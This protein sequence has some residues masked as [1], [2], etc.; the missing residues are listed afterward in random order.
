MAKNI[1]QIPD[2]FISQA[3]PEKSALPEYRSVFMRDRDR[4]MYATAFRRLAGKTQIYT[5]GADD[6][7]KNRLTHSL[8]V[9]QIAR[10][11]ATAL[12]LSEP[13]AEAI[14]LAHDF[15]HTPFGHA[16]EEMLH[17]IM[18]PNSKEV[19]DSPFYRKS[20]K[21]IEEQIERESLSEIV[22]VLDIESIFGFKHNIQSVRVATILEDSYR[23]ENDINIGLNLSNYTLWG[24][25]NHSS[26]K[27]RF[28][29]TQPNYQS[30]FQNMISINGL[31]K[32][33]WSFE[34]YIVKI[35]D[36]IAQW[37]HDLED[38]IRGNAIPIDKICNT[39]TEAIGN[40]LSEEDKDLLV[41][42]SNT[43][44]MTRK[45]LAQLSHIVVN[46]LVNDLVMKSK[47]NLNRLQKEISSYKSKTKEKEKSH[48]LYSR[49]DELYK[50]GKITSSRESII[51]FS[52]KIRPEIFK[53]SIIQSVHHSRNVER[54][55]E[56]GKYIIKKLFQAYSSHPQQMPDG[57]I[58]HFMVEIKEYKSLDEGYKKGMG[59]VRTDFEK[60]LKNMKYPHRII[61][62]RRICD[63]IASMTDRYAIEEYGNLYG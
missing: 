27:Y 37:H 43:N 52:D 56:K 51:S 18:I 63:H 4:I 60:Q 24:M 10:T 44:S 46:T 47:E 23:N 2:D 16:G 32:E 53:N 40:S 7:K 13:L 35:A 42:L 33:A 15:G 49:Y 36:D 57:P 34:G 26:A 38:A 25:L 39:I 45:A 61:L 29:S 20:S 5:I 48:I 30:R 8:E 58:L 55:N 19:K 14:S 50:K 31:N 17:S 11:I 28:K 6:H 22:D 9:A 62:M 21:E 1:F 41:E 59:A 12:N 3:F 54:M